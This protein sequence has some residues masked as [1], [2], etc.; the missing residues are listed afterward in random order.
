M[1]GCTAI[2]TGPALV[3]AAKV[4]VTPGIAS[5]T[6]LV[7]ETPA[8]PSTLYSALRPSLAVPAFSVSAPPPSATL[9]NSPPVAPVTRLESTID[10]SL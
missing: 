5:V 9:M 6:T 2:V 4:S 8:T 7:V 3:S 1:G 10:P